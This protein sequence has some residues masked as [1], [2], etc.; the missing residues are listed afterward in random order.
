[1]LTRLSVW[2]ER[3]QIAA[4]PHHMKD[5]YVPALILDTVEDEVSAHGE[6]PQ[7]G[8]QILIVTTTCVRITG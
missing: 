4:S 7:A 6:R 2:Q 5:E 1:M 8:P 3:H